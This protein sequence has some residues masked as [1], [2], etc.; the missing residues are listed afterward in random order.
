[1]ELHLRV[2]PLGVKE[3]TLGFRQIEEIIGGQLP[4]SAFN[5]REW[6]SNQSNVKN[7]PQA[8]AWINAGFVVDAVHQKSS[9]G[10][11]RFKRQQTA[12]PR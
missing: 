7:R 4:E 5:Y 3:I 9:N 1:L 10:W 11:V 8:R 12:S 6:W 2:E